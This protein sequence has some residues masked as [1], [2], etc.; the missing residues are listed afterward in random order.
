MM[1]APPDFSGIQQIE[2]SSRKLPTFCPIFVIPAKAGIHQ[3][4]RHAERIRPAGYI[5]ARRMTGVKWC[6]A[7]ANF[8]LTH[9]V[10]WIPAFAGMTKWDDPLPEPHASSPEIPYVCSSPRKPLLTSTFTATRPVRA[11]PATVLLLAS[12]SASAMPVG[13]SMR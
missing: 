11:I 2:T 7:A 13:M 4:P 3:R 10:D 6:D 5:F 1:T 12:G 9:C 8:A